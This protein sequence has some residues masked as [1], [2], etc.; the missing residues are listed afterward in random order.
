M[1]GGVIGWQYV[2]KGTI[3]VHYGGV[4]GAQKLQG[5][6]IPHS[7]PTFPMHVSNK[8]H[9]AQAHADSAAIGP[10]QP[11]SI[12]VTHAGASEKTS[13]PLC[14][15][16]RSGGGHLGYRGGVPPVK[17]PDQPTKCR[18]SL[19][20]CLPLSSSERRQVVRRGLSM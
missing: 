19:L 20:L 10:S 5:R 17:L 9:H 4:S 15:L 7:D 1:C 6:K 12:E 11:S 13:Q 3:T 8:H 2:W 18:S 14:F 16:R